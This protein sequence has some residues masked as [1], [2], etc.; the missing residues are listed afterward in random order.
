MKKRVLVS[1]NA[2][3]A[4]GRYMAFGMTLVIILPA[5]FNLAV[6]IGLAPT[7]GVAL[8][9]FSYGGS[10]MLAA[11]FAV[12]LLVNVAKRMEPCSAEQTADHLA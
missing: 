12:G 9:F 8:P 7:K 10:F 6:V 11:L 2:P 3:D 4:L 5:I 1:C